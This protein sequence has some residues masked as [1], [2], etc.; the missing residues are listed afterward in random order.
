MDLDAFTI[1]SLDNARTESLGFE[2][3]FESAGIFAVRRQNIKVQRD[4]S[5]G[6]TEATGDEGWLAYPGAGKDA[7]NARGT[8][9]L[10]LE[11]FRFAGR[12]EVRSG[13]RRI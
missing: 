3:T 11:G 8:V 2:S 4:Y 10:S 5:L 13:P 9:Q 1:D 7:G 6:F 12:P